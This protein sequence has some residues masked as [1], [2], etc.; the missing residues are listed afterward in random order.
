MT[1]YKNLSGASNVVA[2]EIDIDS[3]KVQFQPGRWS[4]Y[5]YTYQSAGSAA[6]ESMKN[7]ADQGHGL[8]SYI[9]RNKPGYSSK[10]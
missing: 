5:I 4:I 3:I 10:S 7:L 2:Y 6:I 1:P 8:N 9:S